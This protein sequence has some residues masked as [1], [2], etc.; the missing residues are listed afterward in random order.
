MIIETAFSILLYRC[1]YSLSQPQRRA[2]SLGMLILTVFPSTPNSLNSFF[3]LSRD[4]LSFTLW[5]RW[6]L[7][8]H[9]SFTLKDFL[10]HFKVLIL[11][12]LLIFAFHLETVLSVFLGQI[13]L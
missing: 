3:V 11:P 8:G 6:E 10:K 4:G 13:Q 9:K 1:L 5:D 2:L 7:Q 12:L